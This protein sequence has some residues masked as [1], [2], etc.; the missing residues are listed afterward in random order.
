MK[1]KLTLLLIL[2]T[3]GAFSCGWG[4]VDDLY[5]FYNLF[6]QTNISAKAYYPFLRE[7]A[8]HFYNADWD[9]EY[10]E[11]NVLLWQQLLTEWSEEDIRKTFHAT[12]AEFKVLL[13]KHKSDL[14]AQVKAYMNFARKCS[15][16]FSDRRTNSWEYRDI[17]KV[18]TENTSALIEEGS[19]LFASAKNDQLKL[20]YAYQIIRAFHYGSQY[21]EAIDFYEEQVADQF[22]K[23]ELYYYAKDQV[24]GCYYSLYQYEKAAYFFIDIFNNSIDRKTSAFLSYQYCTRN[25]AEGKSFFKDNQDKAAYITITGVRSMAGDEE[26]LDR[27]YEVAPNDEKVELIFMRALNDLERTIWP[28]HIGVKDMSL[29]NP[30]E[31][32]EALEYLTAFVSKAKQNKQIKNQAFWQMASSYLAFCEGNIKEAQAELTKVNDN[33]LQ[34]QKAELTKVYEVFTWSKMTVDHEAYLANFLDG[35]MTSVEVSNWQTSEPSWKYLIMDQ[36]AHLYYKDGKLAQSYFVHNDIESIRRIASLPLI[37]DILAFVQKPQKNAFEQMLMR[38]TNNIDGGYSAVDYIKYIKGLYYLK[39]AN[40]QEAYAWLKESKVNEGDNMV[41]YQVSAKIFSNNIM[42]CFSCSED[43]V[44]VDSVYL[45]SP[46]SFIKSNF[47]KAELADYVAKLED[48]AQNNTAQWK[49]KLAFYLLGNFYY[50]ASNSGYYRDVLIGGGNCCNYNFF[51]SDYDEKNRA[52][53]IIES[54]R[55]YNLYDLDDHYDVYNKLSKKSYGFYEKVI[56]NSTDRELNA[57]CLY[58]MAKCELNSMYNEVKSYKYWGYNGDVTDEIRPYKRSFRRLQ[59][60]YDNT[61]F[62]KEIIEECS[63]FRYYTSV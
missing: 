41:S 47:T 44:M 11:G 42:E 15:A 34:G 63:F 32:R 14:D 20:R 43:M 52:S 37:D 5:F 22:E 16:T 17:M 49:R 24:A 46:F 56:E 33:S 36:V 39:K 27:L 8:N 38:K 40:P 25:G 50:N 9:Q 1:R 3:T 31:G 26:T 55:G 6:E 7:D 19:K 51:L 62:Y 53:T 21:Q 10:H 18:E 57:R 54:N 23:S 30:E 45:A 4:P 28:T 2:V 58:L 59:N 12:D 35:E 48:M 60:E 29:P 13:S 61:Q